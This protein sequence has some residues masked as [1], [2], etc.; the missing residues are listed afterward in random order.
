[1]NDFPLHLAE[2]LQQRIAE[3]ALRTPGT[4]AGLIDFSSNDYLGLA[5]SDQLFEATHQLLLQ[6]N[7]KV[8][9]ATGSRL[10]TGNHELYNEAETLLAQFHEADNALIF[11]S[12]YDANVGF[13]SAVPQKGDVVLY[14]EYIHASI[15]DGLRLC[16][17]QS[18]KFQHNDKES[19]Y[20]LIER[21][22]S[23]ATELYIV[24][25]SVFSM[26]GDTPNLEAFADI[27]ERYRGR[28]VVDEAHAVG[29]FGD[30]GQGLLQSY[31]LHKRVFARLVTFGKA[32]GCHGAA[33]LGSKDLT[34]Y[35]SN[36]ARSFIYTTGLPPHSLAAIISSYNTIIDNPLTVSKLHIA[37]SAFKSE[38]ERCHL[39]FILS[40][41]AIH[42][43]I[44]PGNERA[45]KIAAELQRA[46]FSV[47]AILS[48]TV[49]AGQ[50]RLRFCIHGFNTRPDMSRM[51]DV[52]TNALRYL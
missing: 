4:T 20:K 39:P 52:L 30:R 46:G 45:R 43:I 37:I 40:Y 17:A 9:G 12:G 2:K 51:M 42:C 34:V 32:M 7:I 36:F 27:A 18:Y 5:A 41:S 25:E 26:D 22:R 38:T 16:G 10:I 44:V 48:P 24:T 1:M 23:K 19:L 35:L 29:V 3:N 50:E 28:L 15:R 8:N 49:P 47:K 13:F 31:G 21:Y 11:N 33:V 14:D 6:K